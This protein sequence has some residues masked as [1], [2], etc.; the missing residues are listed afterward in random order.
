MWGQFIKEN[1]PNF[2]GIIS[3]DCIG[4]VKFP[5][6]TFPVKSFRYHEEEYTIVWG[7]QQTGE[8]WKKGNNFSNLIFIQIKYVP[9]YRNHE[10][11]HEKKI[12]QF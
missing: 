9:Y 11:N 8:V 5:D 10:T 3:Y 1:R 2:Q 6:Q 4:M 12:N 7:N